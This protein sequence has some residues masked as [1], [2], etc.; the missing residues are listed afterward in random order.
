MLKRGYRVTLQSDGLALYWNRCSSEGIEWHT[1]ISMNAKLGVKAAMHGQPHATVVLT[2][3]MTRR[4]IW[5]MKL[6]YIWAIV[7][8]KVDKPDAEA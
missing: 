3:E 8:A 7:R 5:L 4:Y 1:T 2:V 6:R